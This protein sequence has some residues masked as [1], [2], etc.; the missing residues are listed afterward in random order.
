LGENFS[1]KLGKAFFKKFFC[2][3][4]FIFLGKKNWGFLKISKNPWGEIFQNKIHFI[5]IGLEKFA[6]SIFWTGGVFFNFFFKIF[7]ANTI[8]FA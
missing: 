8:F 1:K 6:I 4:F 7:G 2:F 5:L 3:F